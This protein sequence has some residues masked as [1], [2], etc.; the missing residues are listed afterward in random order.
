[1]RKKGINKKAR[2]IAFSLRNE[3]AN[4]QACVE[5]CYGWVLC[6]QVMRHSCGSVVVRN[7]NVGPVSDIQV[8]ET[9]ITEASSSRE[10]LADV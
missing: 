10:R 6:L 9:R 5:Q 7:R 3:I 1:M 4:E 2:A 8:M